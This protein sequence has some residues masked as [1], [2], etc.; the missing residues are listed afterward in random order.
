MHTLVM[1]LRALAADTAD[2]SAHLWGDQDDITLLQ[3][4]THET[5]D[6]WKSDGDLTSRPPTQIG[7]PQPV[8]VSAQEGDRLTALFQ[9]HHIEPT[10]AMQLRRRLDRR[11]LD[12]DERRLCF[13]CA[14]LCGT[15]GGRRCA[16]WRATEMPGPAIPT[17]MV[18]LLQRCRGFAQHTALTTGL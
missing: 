11:D 17:E 6:T 8:V 5:S 14:H 3:A 9:H 15:A 4:C 13:E 1:R 16:N 18:D 12:A 2:P 7:A 10:Q